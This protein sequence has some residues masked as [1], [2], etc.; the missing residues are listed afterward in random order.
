MSSTPVSRSRLDHEPRDLSADDSDPACRQLVA[1]G[2]GQVIGVYE[3]HHVVGPLPHQK[4]MLY[5]AGLRAENPDGLVADL[6]PVAVRA[7][8]EIPAPP[9]A[10]PGDLRQHVADTGRD[11]DPSRLQHVPWPTGQPNEE[12]GLDPHH[13]VVDKL[14]AVAGHLG[15]PRRQQV[16]R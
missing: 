10:D 1:F 13:L 12:P 11:E 9:L 4:R 7:V 3:E 2:R 8:Q 5:G 15:P 6:P 14:N 16:G